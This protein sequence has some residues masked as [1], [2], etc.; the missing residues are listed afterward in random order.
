MTSQNRNRTFRDP[1]AQAAAA[2][3]IQK[4]NATCEGCAFLQ[5]WPR[6]QCKGEASDFFRMVRDTHTPRCNTYAVRAKGEPSPVKPEPAPPRHELVGHA[7]RDK[8][9]KANRQVRAAS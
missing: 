7:Q 5:K 2:A 1:A 4:Q 9:L 3:H 6:P 8:R